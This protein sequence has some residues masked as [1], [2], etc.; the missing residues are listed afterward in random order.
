MLKELN[1]FIIESGGCNDISQ[2]DDTKYIQLPEEH[3]QQFVDAMNSGE[4]PM[5]KASECPAKR[6]LLHFANTVL[7]V[8]NDTQDSDAIYDVYLA[9]G[10]DSSDDSEM[11]Y[12]YT[13]FSLDNDYQPKLI[14]H[15]GNSKADEKQ[16][17]EE[18]HAAML[19]L[20]GF[21]SAI[22]E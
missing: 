7:F 17:W 21:M 20:R 6:L 2:Y 3:R 5:R 1:E 12:T 9:Q 4:V 19:T 14:S 10:S 13:A 18:I 22:S 16:L 8:N 11:G 15:T